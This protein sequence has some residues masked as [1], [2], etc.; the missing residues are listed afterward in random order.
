MKNFVKEKRMKITEI[1]HE[2][3]EDLP[4]PSEMEPGIVYILND[5]SYVPHI[6]PCGCGSLVNL[7][8]G[9]KWWTIDESEGISFSPSIHNTKCGAHYFIEKGKI[10]WV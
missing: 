3:I 1:T 9:P 10:R 7:R 2:F 4:V 5:R 6:C 8:I